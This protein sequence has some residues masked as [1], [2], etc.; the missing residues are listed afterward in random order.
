MRR[1]ASPGCQKLS[2]YSVRKLEATLT[3]L[4]YHTVIVMQK[5]QYRRSVEVESSV[6]FVLT[7]RATTFF[8]IIQALV[9]LHTPQ[10]IPNQYFTSSFT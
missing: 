3:E 2:L 5:V 8:I 7:E 4:Q 9:R 1:A 10:K 6:I